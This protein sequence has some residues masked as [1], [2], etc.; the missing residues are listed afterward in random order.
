[1]ATN[2]STSIY[3]IHVGLNRTKPPIWRRLLV[4]ST[5]MLP[6]F[7]DVLQVAMGW[8]D[9]HPHQFIAGGKLYGVPD[10]E[11]GLEFT[12]GRKVRLFKLLKHEGDRLTYEY[13][14]GDGWEHTVTLEKVLPADAGVR[15]PACIAG[16]RACPPE[17]CGGVAGYEELLNAIRNP[18]HP[19]HEEILEWIGEDFDPERLDLDA[20][21]AAL[22][23]L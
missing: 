19:E 1:M 2:A 4:T 23:H 10:D 22:N 8:T 9:A 18:K 13:D 6:K 21:N 16:S 7:H 12:D 17:D 5:I 14:F 15:V 11:F 3:Q 20:V